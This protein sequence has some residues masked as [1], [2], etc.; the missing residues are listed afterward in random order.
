MIQPQGGT[1]G[2]MATSLVKILLCVLPPQWGDNSWCLK[3]A[4]FRLVIGLMAPL[5]DELPVPAGATPFSSLVVPETTGMDDW[6]GNQPRL[7]NRWE[8][9][10][11]NPDG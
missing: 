10:L 8:H 7:C 5:C 11:V 6:Y 2:G 1:T 9:W 4:G 3:V